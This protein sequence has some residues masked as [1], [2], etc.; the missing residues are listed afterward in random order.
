MKVFEYLTM[1]RHRQKN[2]HNSVTPALSRLGQEDCF[3]F[4]T[5]LGYGVRSCLINKQTDKQINR[6]QANKFRGDAKGMTE[7]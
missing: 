2:T 7:I 5:S 3:E 4:K 6:Q 1:E